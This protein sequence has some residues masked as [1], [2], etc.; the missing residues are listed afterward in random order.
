M[1]TTIAA[2]AAALA[3]A[4]AALMLAALLAVM[5]AARLLPLGRQLVRLVMPAGEPR[6]R[7]DDG[8]YYP[9]SK[10]EAANAKLWGVPA[11]PAGSFARV[12]APRA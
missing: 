1:V 12:G 5:T 6:V 9:A 10:V 7:A 2:V 8:R 11:A 3:V 4:L